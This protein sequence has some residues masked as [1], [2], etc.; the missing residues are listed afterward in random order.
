[1][2]S[3]VLFIALL[4]MMA[5]ICPAASA[6]GSQSASMTVDPAIPVVLEF[7]GARIRLE[8]WNGSEVVISRYM[9]EAPLDFR[10]NGNIIAF[11]WAR[12][13]GHKSEDWFTRRAAEP[14]FLLKVP[15]HTPVC[16]IA[17]TLYAREG[18]LIQSFDCSRAY[19][20]DC[21]L[22]SG[23]RGKSHSVVA[24]RVSAHGT[25]FLAFNQVSV[26]RSS[27]R[28]LILASLN[29]SR[30]ASVSIS[31]SRVGTLNVTSDLT[32]YM[33]RTSADALNLDSK[34]QHGFVVLLR[35]SLGRLRNQSGIRVFRFLPW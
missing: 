6:S 22:S 16:V 26:Q 12:H 23:F 4:A 18:S 34:V 10:R 24:D 15:R 9:G 29:D 7:S 8:G 19:L 1:M 13:M 17:D 20:R 31:R 2:K 3:C 14:H 25:G 11:D 27:L 28:S 32:M 33:E 21:T 35:S 30:K 5:T